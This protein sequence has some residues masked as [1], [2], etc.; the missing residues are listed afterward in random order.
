M[1]C[2]PSNQGISAA[3]GGRY[4]R[5]V[6]VER[7]AAQVL[8]KQH[9][10]RRESVWQLWDSRLVLALLVCLLTGEWIWRKLV[11]LV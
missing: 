9:T 1:V 10:E 3:T 7:L 4:G 2:P 5:F 8:P 6:D 11:G